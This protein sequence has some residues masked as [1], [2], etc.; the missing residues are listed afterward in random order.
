MKPGKFRK[1]NIDLPVERITN[2]R[3][4]FIAGLISALAILV[5]IMYAFFRYKGVL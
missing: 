5:F 4:W 3:P 2:E 1:L